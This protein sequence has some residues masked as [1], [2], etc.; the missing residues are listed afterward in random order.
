MVDGNWVQHELYLQQTDSKHNQW[1]AYGQ[2]DNKRMKEL[3]S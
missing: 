3:L 1:G 2:P